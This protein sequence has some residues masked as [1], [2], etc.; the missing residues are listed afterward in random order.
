MRR[1]ASASFCR[2]DSSTVFVSL[3][4]LSYT[5][6]VYWYLVPDEF[7]DISSSTDYVFGGSHPLNHICDG[8]ADR[9]DGYARPITDMP[10]CEVT[11]NA[12]PLWATWYTIRATNPLPWPR[13]DAGTPWETQV[14]PLWYAC[15]FHKT[16]HHLPILD[17]AIPPVCERCGEMMGVSWIGGMTR[18]DWK[19]TA[20]ERL[21]YAP[22]DPPDPNRARPYCHECGED[23][24]F[25]LSIKI[26]RSEPS[27][28]TSCVTPSGWRR[29]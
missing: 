23:Y 21:M 17:G 18:Y 29:S 3:M 5:D 27:T 24:S 2:S 10:R 1:V 19:P 28:W 4:G 13:K 16:E 26:N 7:V 12:C 9:P 14:E 22:D 20:F 11:C 15:D 6:L 8:Y 25:Y